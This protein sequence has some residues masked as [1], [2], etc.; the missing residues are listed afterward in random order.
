[1]ANETRE[2]IAARLDRQY[3]GDKVTVTLSSGETVALALY[4]LDLVRGFARDAR[5]ANRPFKTGG[6]ERLA[7]RCTEISDAYDASKITGG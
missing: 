6:L 4:E 3:G 5:S 1:M 2:E 7:S